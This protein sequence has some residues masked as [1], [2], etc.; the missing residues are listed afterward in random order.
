MAGRPGSGSKHWLIFLVIILAIVFFNRSILAGFRAVVGLVIS[1]VMHSASSLPP[2]VAPAS[3]QPPFIEATMAPESTRNVE[4]TVVQVY[5]PITITIWHGW[6]E[7]DLPAV[8][9]ALTAYTADHP[10]SPS[11]YKNRMIW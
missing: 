1:P 8:H 4:A 6:G 3:T 9:T 11:T 5:E 10:M 2:T 7:A